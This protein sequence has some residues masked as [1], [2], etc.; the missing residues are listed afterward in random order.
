LCQYSFAK[1]SQSQTVI[2]E[3]VRNAQGTL[4]QKGTHKKLIKLAPGQRRL[5]VEVVAGKSSSSPSSP[6]SGSGLELTAKA[7]GTGPTNLM[8][9][10]FYSLASLM[11]SCCCCCQFNQQFLWQQ[12]QKV[13]PF[14]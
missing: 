3:K 4:E 9:V 5:E 10:K 1:K 12:Y 14:Y 7:T 2:R 13:R 6:R 8:L 11:S